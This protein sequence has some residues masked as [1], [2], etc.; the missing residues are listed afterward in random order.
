MIAQVTGS[1]ARTRLPLP[2]GAGDW[3]VPGYDKRLTRDVQ[4]ATRVALPKRKSETPRPSTASATSPRWPRRLVRGLYG[5]WCGACVAALIVLVGLRWLRYSSWSTTPMLNDFLREAMVIDAQ[6]FLWAWVFGTVKGPTVLRALAIVAVCLHRRFRE[7]LVIRV[8]GVWRLRR[9]PVVLLLGALVWVHYGFDINPTVG[10][11]C[12]TLLI[13]V[14]LAEQ[15]R[16]AAR[17]SHPMVLVASA[18]VLIGLLVAA[19][20]VVDRIAIGAW[21]LAL[22]ASH[23]YLDGR[24]ASRHLGLLRTA[25]LIPANLVAAALPLALPLHGGRHLGDG[26]GYSFCEVA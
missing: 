21:A 3:G 15:P 11:V 18:I 14:T 22:L 24:I 4:R 13:L 26:L 10:W 19:H 23:R 12:A 20:D 7:Q 17:S 9:L 25:A 8:D 16:L 5:V 2:D 1:C 6:T